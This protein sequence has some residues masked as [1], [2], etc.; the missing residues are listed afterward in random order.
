M[1]ARVGT[2]ESV[3]ALGFTHRTRGGRAGAGTVRVRTYS[4][5][6]VPVYPRRI[7]AAAD[8]WYRYWYFTV[9]Y[10]C[11]PALLDHGAFDLKGTWMILKHEYGSRLAA[12]RQLSQIAAPQKQSVQPQRRRRSCFYYRP[13][14]GAH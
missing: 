4:T 10:V 6:P 11:G 2:S 14:L 13:P 1:K 7:C 8:A 12:G 9:P 5:V 3:V